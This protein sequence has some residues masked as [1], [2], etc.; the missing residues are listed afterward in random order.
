M[1]T[2][3]GVF[4][5]TAENED[6]SCLTCSKQLVLESGEPGVDSVGGEADVSRDGEGGRVQVDVVLQVLT[7]RQVRHHRDLWHRGA[8]L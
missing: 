2:V 5:K 3:V 8:P 4:D 6:F 7:H 1:I